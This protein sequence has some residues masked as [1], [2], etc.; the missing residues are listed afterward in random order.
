MQHKC[1][2]LSRQ[3]ASSAGGVTFSRLTTENHLKV[4]L[5]CDMN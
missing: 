5:E 2:I 1:I 3:G 4:R